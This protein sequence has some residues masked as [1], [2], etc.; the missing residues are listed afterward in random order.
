MRDPAKLRAF[1]LADQLAVAI[2][3]VTKRFPKDERFSLTDQLRRAAVSVPSNIV[4][5]CRR[6]TQIY[7]RR[8]LEIAHGSAQEVRY[9][10]GLSR[11]LGFVDLET[12]QPVEHLSEETCRVLN[13]LI[14]SLR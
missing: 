2:Y 4:E 9:Q 3:G 12:S 14:T 7:Y 5:G 6:T 11:R 13:G 10:I 8:F 1:E